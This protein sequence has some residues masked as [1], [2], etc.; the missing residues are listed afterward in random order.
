V[1]P[2][3]E[4]APKAKIIKPKATTSKPK[5]KTAQNII[6]K[7]NK[8]KNRKT[9]KF[10]MFDEKGN[11]LFEKSGTKNHVKFTNDEWKRMKQFEGTTSTHNHP[12]G[13]SFSFDDFDVSRDLKQSSMRVTSVKSGYEINFKKPMPREVYKDFKRDFDTNFSLKSK[14]SQQMMDDYFDKNG[15]KGAT[16]KVKEL[17][18]ELQ[19]ENWVEM[20]KKYPGYFDYTRWQNG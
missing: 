6:E 4:A 16:E 3:V 9:E 2:K 15:S 13:A 19:H 12:A 1:T 18:R 7:E 11:V 10:Y 8:I 5:P 17:N 20:Q 14:K